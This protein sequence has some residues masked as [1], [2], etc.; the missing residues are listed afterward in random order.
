MARQ[1]RIQYPGAFY[2]VTSRGNRKKAIFVSDRDRLA[3]LE[4]F[5]EAH[6]KFQA[7][8]HTYCLMS[9]HYHFLLETPGA[10]LSRIMH[11]INA[12]YAVHY[13]KKQSRVGH[14]L[15][16]RFKAILVESD[17]YARELSRYIHL[18]PVRAKIVTL[19]EDYLWSSYRDFVGVRKPPPWLKTGLI[20][21]YFGST[22]RAAR[23][24]FIQ[25]VREGIGKGIRNPLRG[26]EGSLILGSDS[27]ISRIKQFY[28]KGRSKDREVPAIGH[29]R[30]LAT[31][32][33]IENAVAEE[34]GL[35]GKLAR[36]IVIYLGRVRADL[37]LN[38]LSIRYQ[39]SLSAVSKIGCQMKTRCRVDK[40][41][42]ARVRRIEEGLLGQKWKV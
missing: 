11:F 32:A 19:P 28:L 21:S 1:L 26:A 2:H 31:L 8:L 36:N 34:P 38:E 35:R 41:L 3:F 33:M 12:S 6:R 30:R 13:N 7:V 40:S 14:L 4:Y 22:A 29:L 20:L 10:N 5:D 15:Q 39:L 37:S 17:L 23:A 16:G 9:N 27:F 25:Y 24:G 42:G 18:N